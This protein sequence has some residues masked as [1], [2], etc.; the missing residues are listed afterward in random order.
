MTIAKSD[1]DVDWEMSR[2]ELTE[3]LYSPRMYIFQR[4]RTKGRRKTSEWMYEITRE[5]ELGRFFVWFVR[6]ERCTEQH[7]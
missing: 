7:F 1:Q 6:N 2:G 3:G 4:L 5:L